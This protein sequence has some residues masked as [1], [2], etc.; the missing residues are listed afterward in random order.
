[1]HSPASLPGFTHDNLDYATYRALA[2][3]HGPSFFI[4]EPDKLRRNYY[5]L[6]DAFFSSYPNVQIAYSY[7]T[8]YIPH[9]CHLLHEQGAWA[10]VVSDME[11]AS[12]L[13]LGVPISQII[14]NGP[15]KAFSAFRDAA[16]GGATLI[17]DS[18]RDL[19]L[20]KAVSSIAP[21]DSV[22]KVALRCNFSIDA[23]ISRFGFDVDS[24]DFEDA[25]TFIDNLNLVRL[26]GLHCHF[27]NRDLDSYRRR[28][29]R[30]VV[31]CARVF[32][33]Q[34]PEFLNIGGGFFSSLPPTILA[35][36]TGPYATF[37][38]YGRVVGDLLT[39]VYGHSSK[40]PTL[41]LEPGTALV[42]DVM[43]FYTQVVSTKEIR[44]R[45][46]ATVAGSIFDISPNAK[47]KL[48]PVAPILDPDVPRIDS[49][50]YR[51]TGF[52][53]IEGDILT[54][55]LVAP[56][57]AGDALAYGNV[58]SYSVVMRPPFILPS[59]PVLIKRL[60]N[61]G[62]DLIKPS[63]SFDDVFGVYRGLK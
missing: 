7:K 31:L 32:P 17:L 22:I 6:R 54:E 19:E 34:P 56:L 53:C 43:S 59:F 11:Y 52:T 51:I 20:L 25:L 4:L 28:V 44:G 46:F 42:A 55:S 10:E 13:S 3:E 18:H 16:L 36:L 2:S 41:F 33:R 49:L 47:S 39:H 48:L 63:Q 50:D 38:D 60:D 14:F 58:G 45:H 12:A 24:Q 30:M 26:I 23:N 9:V 21:K 29:E 27:P 1:M 8:N 62:Y 5:S 35:S 37:Q 40:T 57:Q 15:Y 61:T